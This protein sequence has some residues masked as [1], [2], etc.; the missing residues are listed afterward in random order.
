VPGGSRRL[1]NVKPLGGLK[2]QLASA[3]RDDRRLRSAEVFISGVDA[4]GE[5]RLV[6]DSRGGLR[7]RL[8]AGEYALRVPDIP[9]VPFAVRDTGWTPV[10]VR[11]P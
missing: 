5:V 7:Y 2:L 4:D 10:R 3:R 8:A 9:D 11:L 6:T 1:L